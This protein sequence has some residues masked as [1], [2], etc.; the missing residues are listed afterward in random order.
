MDHHA[1]LGHV[2]A[3]NTIEKILKSN[4]AFSGKFQNFILQFVTPYFIYRYHYLKSC[5]DLLLFDIELQSK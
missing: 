3:N 2:V 1:T 5:H 4:D